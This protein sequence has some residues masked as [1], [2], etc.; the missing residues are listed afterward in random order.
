MIHHVDS[1]KDFSCHRPGTG[2]VERKW[3][4]NLGNQ[5]P[6]SAQIH[7]SWMGPQGSWSPTIYNSKSEVWEEMRVTQGNIHTVILAILFFCCKVDAS[8]AGRKMGTGNNLSTS[9]FKFIWIWK[10]LLPLI[11]A[12]VDHTRLATRFWNYFKFYHSGFFFN[13]KRKKNKFTD[14]HK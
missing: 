2:C 4:Q 8:R 5:T 11:F 12:R 6:G 13:I 3:M 1:H 7:P 14:I 9:T 10:I